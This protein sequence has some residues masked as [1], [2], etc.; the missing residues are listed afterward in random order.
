MRPRVS[1]MNKENDDPILEFFADRDIALSPR[2]L[3]YNLDAR[4]NID[5]PYSTI[6]HRLGILVDH[7]LVEKEDPEGGRYAITEK[8]RQ[9]LAGELDRDDL[10]D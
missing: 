2:S 10:E 9:Y 3:Q 8:G 6:N 1:W 7:G 5:I 4:E